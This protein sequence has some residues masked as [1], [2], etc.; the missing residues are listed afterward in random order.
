MFLPALGYAQFRLV[1]V[2][3][4]FTWVGRWVETI[5]GA[6]LVLELTGSPFWVGM[7]GA[8]RFSLTLLGPFCG[9][10]SDRVNERL[11]L[12]TSQV[13]YCTATLAVLALFALSLLEVWHLFAFTF[14]GSLCYTFDYSARYSVACG[15]V[16]NHHITS[17]VSLMQATSGITSVLG[18]LIGGNLLEKIGASACFTVIASAFLLS[19]LVLFH[20][21]ISLKDCRSKGPSI[22]EELVSGLRYIKENSFLFSLVL[23]AAMVN[24][25][26]FPSLYTLMPIFA[27]SILGTGADGYGLLMAGAG[28]GAILGALVT[29]ILPRSINQGKLLFG[30]IIAWPS[31]FGVLS[32]ARTFEFSVAL[33]FMAGTAQGISMSLVQAQLMLRSSAEMRGR[34]SGARTLA[35][36]ALSVGNL[37]T[38][39][40]A[41]L[42]GVPMVFFVNSLIFVSIAVLIAVW[43]PELI[44]CEGTLIPDRTRAIA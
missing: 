22:C 40:E 21:K 29:G 28:A 43:E 9:A 34:V 19:F 42:W 25:F 17:A 8:C 33:L 18:P 24:L 2:S 31:F 36:S 30:A 44:K 35:I 7:L 32:L 39:Y 1:W 38:G 5:V 27:R 12:L 10:L 41:S 3:G 15:V 37:M 14:I 4:L 26:L 20:L 16:L 13:V 11:V 23:L 6:W